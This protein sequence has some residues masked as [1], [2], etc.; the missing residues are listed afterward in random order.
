MYTD[1]LPRFSE[2]TSQKIGSYVYALADEDDRV[3]YVGKGAA[4][5]VFDH[6]AG[7][8]AML[9]ADP[10][11]IYRLSDEDREDDAPD[12]SVETRHLG[13]KQ[14]R[15]GLMLLAGRLPSMHIVR[16]SLDPV[17]ASV[18]ESAL[19]SVLD[20]Q[21]PSGLTNLVAGHGTRKSGL[22]TAQELEAVSGEPFDL[23][24]LPGAAGLLG[25]SVV[26]IN[27]N[28]R[29][30]ELKKGEKALLEVSE[31]HWKVNRDRANRCK[32]AIVHAGAIVRG[33]FEIDCCFPSDMHACRSTFRPVRHEPLAGHSF[34]NKNASSLFGVAGAGSQNP[35]RYARIAPLAQPDSSTVQATGIG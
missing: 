3:F 32:F 19:I 27:I 4:N 1:E 30:A 16:D 31:G 17:E 28:R 25:E 20:W 18:I 23:M 8:Q 12:D 34:I 5:R 26:A 29:W 33:V 22:K 21:L 15:V 13:D 35:I 6:V 24:A 9:I 14:R 2:L 7:V 11:A 10:R